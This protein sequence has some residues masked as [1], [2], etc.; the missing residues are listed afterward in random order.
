MSGDVA[1][2]DIDDGAVSRLVRTATTLFDTPRF[3]PAA[4]VGG[5]AVTIRLA[6]LDLGAQ[7]TPQVRLTRRVGQ[8]RR[9]EQRHQR[10]RDRNGGT[11]GFTTEDRVQAGRRV[12]RRIGR[13]HL[14]HL[15]E[16]V[17]QRPI[18]LDPDTRP[19]RFADVSV[20]STSYEPSLSSS[21]RSTLRAPRAAS[22]QRQS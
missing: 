14:D 17:E 9:I 8:Q 16:P 21:A 19:V 11:I 20:T 7:L 22:T 2:I 10:L 12:L 6:G 15:T 3:Q 13:V 1:L 5:L 18:D 4:L